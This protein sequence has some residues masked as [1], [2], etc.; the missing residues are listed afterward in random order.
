[1][2]RAALVGLFVAVAIAAPARAADEP[3]PEERAFVELDAGKTTFFVGEPIPLTLRVLYDAPWFGLH[4]APPSGSALGV[5]VVVTTT[6][7]TGVATTRLERSRPAGLTRTLALD[8]EVT[9]A[10]VAAPRSVGG[11]TF[12]VLEVVR[13]LV[14]DEPGTLRIAA[15]TLRFVHAKRTEDAL[16]GTVPVDPRPVVGRGA[17]IELR[18]EALPTAGRPPDFSGAVGRFTA[19]ATVE[20]TDVVVGEPFALLVTIEGEGAAAVAREAP[21]LHI[22]GVHVLARRSHATPAGGRALSYQ[23]SVEHPDVTAVPPIAFSYFEPAPAL[24]YRTVRTEAIPLRVTGG[25]RVTGGARVPGVAHDGTEWRASD[26][27][28]ARPPHP[29]RI[30]LLAAAA[31]A[32]VAAAVLLRKNRARLR[33]AAAV[34][35]DVGLAPVEVFRRRV[36]R[37]ESVSDA[38]AEALARIAGCAPAAVVGPDLAARLT[39][40]GA[41]PAAA[42]RAAAAMESLV[43]ARYGGGGTAIDAGTA[44]AILRDASPAGAPPAAR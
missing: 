35:P 4:A 36:A 21:D 18:V 17:G 25:E 11:R 26:D 32:L 9:E 7:P 10:N 40:A 22:D 20:R 8:D 43:A 34:A 15:P 3:P 42:E 13:L 39:A 2:R 33:R 27:A 31:A 28:V 30:A 29:A 6:P 16:G 24:A 23:V 5:P 41:S 1:V 19:R 37:G 12:E 38:L 44:E 14:A